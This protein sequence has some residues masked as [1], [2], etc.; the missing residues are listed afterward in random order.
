MMEL[1]AEEEARVQAAD[2][3]NNEIGEEN[4]ASRE[5]HVSPMSEEFEYL[6]GWRVWGVRLGG[7]LV[8]H[9]DSPYRALA[10]AL[11]FTADTR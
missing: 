9:N 8:V 4:K 2:S 1:P 7:K 5:V 11:R 10:P 6:A 3:A